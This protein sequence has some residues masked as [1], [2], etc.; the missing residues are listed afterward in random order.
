MEEGDFLAHFGCEML[1]KRH[2]L[3]EVDDAAVLWQVEDW[4]GLRRGGLEC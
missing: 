4:A 3:G 1:G 2:I